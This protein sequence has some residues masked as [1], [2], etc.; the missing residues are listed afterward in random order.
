MTVSL[1]C[2]KEI[3]GTRRQL[4]TASHLKKKYCALFT[5]YCLFL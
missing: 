3:E 1:C 5:R 2:A 4:I